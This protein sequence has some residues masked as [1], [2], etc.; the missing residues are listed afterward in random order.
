[1][2]LRQ[3]RQRL[4]AFSLIEAAI[5]L[6]IIGVVIGGIWVAVTRISTNRAIN[7]V[8]QT[9]RQFIN[10]VRILVKSAAQGEAWFFTTTVTDLPYLQIYPAE[11]LP[12]GTEFKT[13][14]GVTIGQYNR[15]PAAALSGTGVRVQ[16]T[17]SQRSLC[18]GILTALTRTNWDEI[19]SINVTSTYPWGGN[20][21]TTNT[22]L[23]G[24]ISF[25][26]PLLATACATT[27]GLGGPTIIVI[28]RIL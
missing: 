3:N 16:L 23:T 27:G 24:P 11:W 13:R 1:M 14:S 18:R 17:S 2:S 6:A 7:E 4:C 19:R 8:S 12:A 9:S 28:W 5:V 10:S 22:V 15:N 25:N 26:D 21:S 20:L